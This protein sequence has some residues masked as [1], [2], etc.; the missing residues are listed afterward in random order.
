MNDL[1][2]EIQEFLEKNPEAKT[3]KTLDEKNIVKEDSLEINNQNT[4]T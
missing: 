3:D 2:L 1:D 4:S